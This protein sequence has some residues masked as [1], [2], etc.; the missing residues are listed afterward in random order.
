MPKS[1]SA[2]T[3]ACNIKIKEKMQTGLQVRAGN[4]YNA[5]HCI[6]IVK[7]KRMQWLIQEV[8][9]AFSELSSVWEYLVTKFAT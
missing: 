9:A 8:T 2:L 3:T 4:W 1:E 7:V 6:N 5:G